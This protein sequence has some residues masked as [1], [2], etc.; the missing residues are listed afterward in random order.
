MMN[1]CVFLCRFACCVFFLKLL[2]LSIPQKNANQLE[3]LSINIRIRVNPHVC[4]GSLFFP[5]KMTNPA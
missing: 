4:F 3:V 2:Q 5:L 1:F